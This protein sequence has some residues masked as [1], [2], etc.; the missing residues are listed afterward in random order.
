MARDK[1]LE[2][3]LEPNQPSVRYLALTQLLGK[4]ETDPEVREARARIPSTGWV[5]DLL[6]GR[7]PAGWWAR[8]K[9][10]MEPRFVAT[11]WVM[12]ALAHHEAG[13]FRNRPDARGVREPRKDSTD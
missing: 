8:D 2:W 4:R 12:L 7:D 1:V 3:L 11:H 6:A 9:G 5:A 10:W 13:R